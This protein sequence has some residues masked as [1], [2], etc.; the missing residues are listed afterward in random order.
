MVT[1]DIKEKRNE[2]TDSIYS[3]PDNAPRGAWTSVSYVNP[4]SKEER[5]NL[6]Y[7][8]INPFTGKTVEHHTNAWKY[9]INTYKNHV[10]ENRLYWEKT[11]KTHT[12]G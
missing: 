7:P 11:V 1:V 6:V 5:P 10:K 8:L 4:A 9:E 3:S 12:Q 2:K